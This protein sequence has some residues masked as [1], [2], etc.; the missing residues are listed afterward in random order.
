MIASEAAYCCFLKIRPI[1]K[2]TVCGITP[3][4]YLGP[5]EIRSGRLYPH[6]Q[7]RHIALIASVAAGCGGALAQPSRIA[8]EID[9]KQRV[10][11]TGHVNP[12]ALAENDLGRVSPSM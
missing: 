10:T 3:S 5:V 12:R 11:L 1:L 9:N 6:M 4:C 2:A 7:I 8:G